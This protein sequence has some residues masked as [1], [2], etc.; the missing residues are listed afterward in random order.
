MKEL[1]AEI[2]NNNTAKVKKM[3]DEKYVKTD[4]SDWSPSEPLDADV[5][6]G[7]RPVRR[8]AYRKGGAVTAMIKKNGKPVNVPGKVASVR[9]DRI[10]KKKGGELRSMS[11]DEFINRDVKKANEEREGKKHVGGLKTGGRAKKADGG[12]A[13]DQDTSAPPP[14]ARK[15]ILPKKSTSA[16]PP[17]A[18]PESDPF[19]ENDSGPITV[20]RKSGGRAKKAFGGGNPY[21]PES[22]PGGQ[23]MIRR[24]AG[25]ATG[26][27]PTPT[28][29]PPSFG[30]VQPDGGY[31]FTYPQSYLQT[32]G[33]SGVT[34][35]FVP[36]SLPDQPA[37]KQG[38]MPTYTSVPPS[39]RIAEFN[40]AQGFKRGGRTA[41]KTNIHININTAPK[42]PPM[43]MGLPAGAP[44]P[45]P[46]AGGMPP[47]AGMP[48][49]GAGAPT[50]APPGA[51]AGPRPGP[52]PPGFKRGGR[53]SYP[54]KDGAG[55]G[56]GRLEKEKAYGERP[57]RKT[58]GR[59]AYP[60][61]DASAGGKGRLQKIEAYG[62]KK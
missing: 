37:F 51:M 49:P 41:K 62:K 28:Y 12:Q 38:P 13:Y 55:S 46:P 31:S 35:G 30:A 7:M 42:L 34:P 2:R 47:A 39:P 29:Q 27:T 11:S 1:R 53:T 57:G 26:G 56:L 32:I 33:G 48:P 25:F 15:I 6:T 22:N 16:P 61:E 40:K 9:G 54:I 18:A 45:P 43:P 21:I 10:A 58:G 60:I 19:A 24:A 17:A 50:M 3:V 59:A 4:S 23:S 14:K 5:K 44:V 52:P 8:R 20:G 36:N